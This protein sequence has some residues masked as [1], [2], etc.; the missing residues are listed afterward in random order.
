MSKSEQER[1]YK[2]HLNL[3]LN[4]RDEQFR[5]KHLRYANA[6]LKSY[7][8]FKEPEPVVE[9]EKPVEVPEEKS[10]HKKERKK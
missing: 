10:K 1:L 8:E 6:I 3:S 9:E 4:G 5:A 2:H 7:P